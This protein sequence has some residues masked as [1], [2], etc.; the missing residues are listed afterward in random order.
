MS[1]IAAI[2]VSLPERRRLLTEAVDSVWRQTRQPDHLL[3]GVDYAHVG[4]VENNNRLIRAAGDVDWLA[5]LHDD[6]LWLPKHLEVAERFFGSA[7]VIVSDFCTPGRKW[8][9]PKQQDFSMLRRTNWFPPSAVVVRR[10]VFGLWVEPSVAPPRD[11]VDW[12]NWRR[13]LEG[14][15]RFVHTDVESVAYRFDHEFGNGS[16]A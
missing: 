11:W 10:E 3:V 14:G 16:W 6:D 7:D 1:S 4:E 13:L 15:A 12:S 8:D 2:V 5:F 9:I